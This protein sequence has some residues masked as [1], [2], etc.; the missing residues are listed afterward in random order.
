VNAF[1]TSHLNICSSRWAGDEGGSDGRG[2]LQALEA[3]RD[4]F[5]DVSSAD[6]AE[7]VVGNEREGSASLAGRLWRTIVPVSAMARVEAVRT[8]SKASN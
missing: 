3:L 8:A 4:G 1:D 5:D 2:G 6:D 7:V